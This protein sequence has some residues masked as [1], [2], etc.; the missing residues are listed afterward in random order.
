MQC[1][2]NKDRLALLLVAASLLG[3]LAVSIEGCT[4]AGLLAGMQADEAQGTGGP[5]KLLEIRPGQWMSLER[6]DGTSRQGRFITLVRDSSATDTVNSALLG[7]YSVKIQGERGEEVLPLASIAKV[8]TPTVKGT[9]IGLLVGVTIDVLIIRSLSQSSPQPSCDPNFDLPLFSGER[10][11]IPESLTTAPA[12]VRIDG[13][14]SVVPD[15]R[16]ASSI[17]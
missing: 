3:V 8:R 12:G 6:W 17:P 4:I 13:D 10:I 15:P 2:G 11:A 7:L 14:R 16:G 1:V 5:G 9:V